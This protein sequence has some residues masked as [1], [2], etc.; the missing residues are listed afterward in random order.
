MDISSS[1]SG[2]G[3]S[4]YR[5]I[6]LAKNPVGYWRL[7]EVTGP[8][9]VDETGNGHDGTY[10]GGVTYQEP[11]ALA[12]DPNT[13]VGFD[14]LD[15]YVEVPDSVQFSQMT[16]G[17]GLTVEV[18]MRPDLLVF[19]GE[20]SEHYIH[21]LGKAQPAGNEWGFRFYSHRSARPNRISAYIWNPEG[22]QGAGAYFED[23]IHHEW[24]HVV[25]CY[26]PGDMNDPTAGV[27]IYKNGVLRGSP[28]STQ[29]AAY[30]KGALYSAYDIVP[31]H[32]NAPL[33]FGTR[34][35][36]SFLKGR[37]DEIAIY[38]RVLTADEILENYQVGRGEMNAAQIGE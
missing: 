20:N 18:W 1:Q 14:G 17:A 35:L 37:L 19:A 23:K 33:R 24:I 6:V 13:A 16:S 4:A 25:A 32:S 27:S 26:D 8:T 15:A 28:D 5:A 10:F 11:G 36:G 3:S 31:V 22:L 38:P 9:A 34:D 12:N 29:G 7:G 21:W 2:P 30:Q